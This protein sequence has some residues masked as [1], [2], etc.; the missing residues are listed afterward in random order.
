MY[1][2]ILP[3][4]LSDKIPQIP[5]SDLQEFLSQVEMLRQ[6]KAIFSSSNVAPYRSFLPSAIMWLIPQV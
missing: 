6:A 4:E 1:G 3:L 2:R 5:V